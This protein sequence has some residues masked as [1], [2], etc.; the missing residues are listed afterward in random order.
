[1]IGMAN[2]LTITILVVFLILLS[3]VPAYATNATQMS[4]SDL[5]LTGPQTIQLYENGVLVGTY[6][7]TS[8]EIPL[9]DHDFQIVIKPELKTAWIN[10]ATFLTEFFGLLG[11]YGKELLLLALSIGIIL[12]VKK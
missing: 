12:A 3:I 6:N 11:T 9:P 8:S 7:T 1:M 5:G 4:F 10:P 2:K